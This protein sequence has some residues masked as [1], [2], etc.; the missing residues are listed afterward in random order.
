MQNWHSYMREPILQGTL[1]LPLTPQTP[2]QEISVEDIGAF[3]AMA[4]QAPAKRLGQ[5]VELAGDELTM[6]QVAELLSRVL[7]RRVSYVQVPWDQFREKA[8]EEMTRMYKWFQDVG[9]HVDIAALRREFPSLSRLEQV[10]RRQDWSEA[11][12][13][14]RKAA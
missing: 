1:P 5:T 14:A 4:F 11:E 7:G 2:L 13:T 8:G 9:Y 6:T 10:L 3:A 12:S